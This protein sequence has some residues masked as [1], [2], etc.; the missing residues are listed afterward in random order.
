M[1]KEVAKK[2][3]LQVAGFILAG[4]GI[5]GYYPLGLSYFVAAY[6]EKIM[7]LLLFPVMFIGMSLFMEPLQL[8]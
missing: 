7:R 3:L 6:K 2:M 5:L 8:A 4:V 1:K